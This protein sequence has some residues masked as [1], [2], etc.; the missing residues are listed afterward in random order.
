[1]YPTSSA[2]SRKL[3]GTRIR[4]DPLT[5]KNDTNSR[6][7]FGETIANPHSPA[8]RNESWPAS[9]MAPV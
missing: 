1:M 9:A 3:T 8:E 4:P 6:A 2:L 7:A 5:P